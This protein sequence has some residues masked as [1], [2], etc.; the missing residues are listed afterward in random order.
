LRETLTLRDIGYWSHFI[1]DASQPLHISIHY[2]G[3]GDYPNPAGYSDSHTIHARFETALVRA[4]ATDAGVSADVGAYIPS[5]TPIETRVATYMR[6]SL[7]GV[8]R[9]YALEAA[10]GID[11]ASPDATA[12]VNARLAAGAT[13]LRDLVADAWNQSEEKK[14][15][16]PPVAVSDLES[17]KIPL[18]RA[19]L[20]GD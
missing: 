9:V 17:G 20:G 4:A 16:Y 12:F 11:G 15:G 5:Q 8:P 6:T 7:A 14:I 1:G 3:W 13:E 2:N 19:V 18:T 10:G